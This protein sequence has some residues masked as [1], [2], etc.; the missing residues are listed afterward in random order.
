MPLALRLS[1]GLGST[2]LAAQGRSVCCLSDGRDS[3]GVNSSIPAVQRFEP[4][5]E[6]LGALARVAGDA[7]ERDVLSVD[8]GFVVDDVLPGHAFTAL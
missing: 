5:R 8:Q 1:E 3:T 2:V 7:A 4:C 6:F